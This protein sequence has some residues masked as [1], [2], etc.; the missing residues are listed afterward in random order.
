MIIETKFDR[1]DKV[2]AIHQGP[3][4]WELDWD[5]A[6]ATIG[7][8]DVSITSSPASWYGIL[9]HGTYHEIYLF[10]TTAEA[11]AECDRRN[12]EAAG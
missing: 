1:G 11:Q 6:S 12:E 7:R 4:K 3:Q 2:F 10:P 5:G 9:G 8:I